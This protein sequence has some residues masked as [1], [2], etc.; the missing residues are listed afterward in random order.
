MSDVRCQYM[1]MYMYM[2]IYQIL[3]VNET[4]SINQ[5][6]AL[7]HL[8]NIFQYVVMRN[9]LNLNNVSIYTLALKP[10]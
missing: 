5:Y 10:T 4:P 9:G 8:N 2:Y 3:N 6:K 7:H 1:Y